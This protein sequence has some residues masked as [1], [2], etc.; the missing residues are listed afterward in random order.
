MGVAEFIATQ[1]KVCDRKAVLLA[2]RNE[3]KV[4]EFRQLLAGELLTVETLAA[5]AELGEVEEGSLAA[6]LLRVNVCLAPPPGA[7]RRC[8]SS[9][10]LSGP[11]EWR[12]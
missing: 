12:P 4:R 6:Q 11:P 9:R 2:T 1:Q 8:T 7:N 10:T 3:G 5:R